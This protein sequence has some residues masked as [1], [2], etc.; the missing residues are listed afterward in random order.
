MGRFR[1][2]AEQR[3]IVVRATVRTN[4]WLGKTVGHSSH[5]ILRQLFTVIIE[6]SS[7]SLQW[8]PAADRIAVAIVRPRSSSWNWDG[9]LS[10]WL[11]LAP[12]LSGRGSD[13]G[14]NARVVTMW[15][16][17]E[18]R[19]PKLCDFAKTCLHEE[20]DPSPMGGH[21]V[22]RVSPDKTSRWAA[23]TSIIWALL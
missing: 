12:M 7:R 22:H 3:P 10:Q 11:S 1:S 2:C 19:R 20:K 5:P 15:R 17:T 8:Q 23:S 14:R 16:T 21:Q 13:F 4:R 9:Q 18:L 6:L